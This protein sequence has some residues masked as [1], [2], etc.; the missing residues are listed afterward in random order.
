[1]TDHEWVEVEVAAA[2]LG[3][4]TEHPPVG[5]THGM[6]PECVARVMSEGDAA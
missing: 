3:I 5:M 6:C 4:L 1:V 2:R